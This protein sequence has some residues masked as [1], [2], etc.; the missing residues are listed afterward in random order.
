MKISG[1]EEV[2]VASLCSHLD[3]SG[4]IVSGYVQHE[5]MIMDCVY[6]EYG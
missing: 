5:D 4:V 6:S 2:T 1:L 3:P